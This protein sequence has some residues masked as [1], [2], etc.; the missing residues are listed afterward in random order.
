MARTF[1]RHIRHHSLFEMMP[2]QMPRSLLFCCCNA[3]RVH[4]AV[5]SSRTHAHTAFDG[6][7]HTRQRL[8][9]T[10]TFSLPSSVPL[11]LIHTFIECHVPKQL[12]YRFIS[13]TNT[14]EAGRYNAIMVKSEHSWAHDFCF[15]LEEVSTEQVPKA[16]RRTVTV[17]AQ[18]RA[19]VATSGFVCEYFNVRT[20]DEAKSI[21]FRLCMAARDAAT[22]SPLFVVRSAP[23]N[24]RAH[25]KTDKASQRSKPA[26]VPPSLISLQPLPDTGSQLRDLPFLGTVWPDSRRPNILDQR[27]TILGTLVVQPTQYVGDLDLLIAAACPVR[28]RGQHYTFVASSSTLLVLYA[29]TGLVC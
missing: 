24:V 7:I 11:H 16:D 21:E 25:S 23:F 12:R 18:L 3:V 29:T 4:R 28:V 10:I 8:Q 2:Y 20:I 1:S 5:L 14:I 13:D 9:V 26:T 22:G 27:G 17:R 15:L 6:T 19:S